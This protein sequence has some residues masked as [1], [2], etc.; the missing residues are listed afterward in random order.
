MSNKIHII[1]TAYMS[2]LTTWAICFEH[3]MLG[4][5]LFFITYIMAVSGMAKSM[6]RFLSLW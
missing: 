3:F 6:K 1:V 5:P 4:I 2:V